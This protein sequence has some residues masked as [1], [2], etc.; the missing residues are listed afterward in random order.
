MSDEGRSHDCVPQLCGSRRCGGV[1]PQQ[2]LPKEDVPRV[3]RVRQRRDP[4]RTEF[5]T[6]GTGITQ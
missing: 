6:D 1:R 2:K 4:E 3:C 5:C